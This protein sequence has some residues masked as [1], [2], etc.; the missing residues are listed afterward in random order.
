MVLGIETAT[1]VCGVGLACDQGVL[2][3]YCLNRKTVHAE[4]LPVIIDRIVNDAGI[5]LHDLKG[6][7]V[8]MGPGSFT[9]LRIGMSVAKGLVY[10]LDIPL[11]AVPTMEALVSLVPE[12]YSMACVMLVARKGE[13]YEGLFQRKQGAWQQ[14]RPYGVVPETEIA[15]DLGDQEIVFIGEGSHQ[16]KTLIR[17]KM[18]KACFLPDTVTMPSGASVALRGI[19]YLKAGK[20]ADLVSLSPLYLKRFQGVA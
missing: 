14:V 12:Y 19:D 17:E 9:G 13:V 16:Y 15:T 3:D 4:R 11:L 1:S 2:A 5:A 7:A 20:V 6:V 8:S 10:G 18:K